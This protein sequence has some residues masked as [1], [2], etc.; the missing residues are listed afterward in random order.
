MPSRKG[1]P[2]KNKMFLLNRLQEQYGEQFH[3][4]MRMAECAVK[5]GDMTKQLEDEGANPRELLVAY[6]AELESWSKI[7][8]YTE[9][10]LRA[11]EIKHDN[12]P[13]VKRIDLRGKQRDPVV[14]DIDNQEAIENDRNDTDRE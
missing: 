7:A 14:I 2:N 3:P 11:V 4:I 12:R 9:P 8:E 6:R 13:T 5:M 1:S 10:K